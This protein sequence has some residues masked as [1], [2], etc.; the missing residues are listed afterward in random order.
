MQT[1]DNTAANEPNTI[2]T[3][4]VVA[5]TESAENTATAVSAIETEKLAETAAATAKINNT[6]SSSSNI[7]KMSK[8]AATVADPDKE[9]LDI[10]TGAECEAKKPKA[11]GTDAGDEHDDL[12]YRNDN[13]VVE[14][15]ILGSMTM[16][17][18]ILTMAALSMSVFIGSL[19]QTIIASSLPNIAEQFNAL[20]SVSW[21]ATGFLLAS[22]AMQPLYGR[23]SD[24]FGRV[25]TLMFGMVIFLVG[26]A[27]SGAANSMGMLIGG[28]VV[29]GLG[30]SALMS[31]VMVI[32]SDISIERERAKV[33]SVFA[34]IWAASS[35]LGPVLGGVF[36]ESKGGWPWAFYF[37]LPVGGL[38][39]IFIVL[40]LR[41]PRPQGSFREKLKRVDFFGMIVLVCGIVM[42]LL[43]LSFGE[44][45]ASWNSPKVLCLLIFGIVVVGIFVII[46]WK[47]PA[48]P[49]MPLR[50]YKNRN[51]GIS[52]L[53]QIFVGAVMFGPTFY[54]PMYFSV[55][56]N[57]SAIKSGL[58]LLPFILPI[59]LASIV[60]GFVVSKTGRYREMQWLGGLLL[61]LGISL[62]SILNE[63]STTG[64]SIGLLLPG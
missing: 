53:Q 28:R 43:A 60:S 47:I 36:T 19:D 31:L 52:L 40:F 46:E 55:I 63:K 57:S 23:L 4:P 39:G 8:G 35:V 48:E 22:T 11:N 58:H 9:E 15:S 51:V 2:G 42:I 56:Q 10:E 33:T 24:I 21:I 25:E 12:A 13:D 64:I 38:A 3:A 34:A 17:R 59:S 50:L 37:S 7:S 44:D 62:L 5:K 27:V 54:I 30:A 45:S 29:Q 16:Q 18:K 49:I 1:T 41:L 61:T 14:K 26:S 20:S 32:V 6:R